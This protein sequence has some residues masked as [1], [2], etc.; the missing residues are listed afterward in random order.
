M[1][2]ADLMNLLDSSA[3]IGIKDIEPTSFTDASFNFDFNNLALGLSTLFQ[4]NPSFFKD[5][6][7]SQRISQLLFVWSQA[8][9]LLIHHLSLS[10]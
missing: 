3:I 9:R 6:T 1:N 8:I 4:Q 10:E 2:L 7:T 5:D